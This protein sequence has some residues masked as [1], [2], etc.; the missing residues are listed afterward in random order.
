M[1]LEKIEKM[2]GDARRYREMANNASDPEVAETLVQIATDLESA[3][4]VI[5]NDRLER[6]SGSL[7]YQSA[8]TVRTSANAS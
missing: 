3:I 7:G 2:R 6:A 5:E 8:K 4:I 1:S